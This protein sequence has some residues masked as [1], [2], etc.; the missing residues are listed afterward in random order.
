MFP[1]NIRKPLENGKQ[2]KQKF[3]IDIFIYFAHNS[4]AFYNMLGNGGNRIAGIR[5]DI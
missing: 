2:R 1:K 3:K 5:A 4:A